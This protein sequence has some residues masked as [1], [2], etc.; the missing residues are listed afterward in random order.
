[1]AESAKLRY[2]RRYRSISSLLP[3]IDQGVACVV[4]EEPVIASAYLLIRRVRLS[5]PLSAAYDRSSVAFNRSVF[6]TRRLARGGARDAHAKRYSRRYRHGTGNR[7]D[8]FRER[9][10]IKRHTESL[11][12]RQPG[13]PV[14]AP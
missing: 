4:L 9:A 12:L 3:Q 2:H 8:Q 14:D 10:E 7:A 5:G 13:N 1:M 11:L 6:S